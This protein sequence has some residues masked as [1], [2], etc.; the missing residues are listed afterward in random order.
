MAKAGDVLA[1]IFCLPC[2]IVA[3]P[4]ICWYKMVCGDE[5]SVPTPRPTTVNT[6]CKY[7]FIILINWRYNLIIAMFFD[8]VATRGVVLEC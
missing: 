6:V 7:F 4:F 2:I 5:S 1:F 8:V 3:C